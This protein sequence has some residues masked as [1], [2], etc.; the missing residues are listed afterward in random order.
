MT[1]ML[2]LWNKEHSG[3]F[4]TTLIKKNKVEKIDN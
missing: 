1:S 3:S 4:K 2:L